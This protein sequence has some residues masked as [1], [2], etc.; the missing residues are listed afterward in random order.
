MKTVVGVVVATTVVAVTA[1]VSMIVGPGGKAGVTVEPPGEVGARTSTEAVVDEPTADDVT[2]LDAYAEELGLVMVRSRGPEPEAFARRVDGPGPDVESL[3]L[4]G[5]AYEDGAEVVLRLRRERSESGF[6][7]QPQGSYV[8]SACYRWLL[9]QSSEGYRPERLD[10]CPDGPVIELG[11]PPVEPGLPDSLHDRLT[12]ALEPPGRDEAVSPEMVRADVRALYEE[13]V[14]AELR[15]PDVEPDHLLSVDDALDG[16]SVA[17]D[18]D[19]VGVAVGVRRECI[20]VRVSP[21]EVSVWVPD[22]I[23]LEPGEVGCSAA[24]AASAG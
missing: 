21:G 22:R 19:A 2:F 13:A 23:S 4:S 16:R 17:T 15:R 18:G 10:E 1:G 9:G 11:P 8:V 6:L 20:M 14:E 24:A 5:S 3:R 7:G 12:G